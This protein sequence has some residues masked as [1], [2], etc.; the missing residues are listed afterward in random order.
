MGMFS[1]EKARF[2][3]AGQGLR[4][5]SWPERRYLRC[6]DDET[7]RGIEFGYELY[8]LNELGEQVSSDWW[9]PSPEDLAASD[10]YLDDEQAA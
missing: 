6:V 2:H 1:D 7:E 5:Y 3:E 8:V 4:R 10:W 9:E